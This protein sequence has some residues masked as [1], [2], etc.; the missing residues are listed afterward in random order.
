MAGF[1]ELYNRDEKKY[2]VSDNEKLGTIVGSLIAAG[3]TASK[4]NSIGEV[5]NLALSGGSVGYTSGINSLIAQKQKDKELDFDIL[6][7]QQAAASQV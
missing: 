7:K 1:D 2:Q 6:Y 5:L 3:M 4:G